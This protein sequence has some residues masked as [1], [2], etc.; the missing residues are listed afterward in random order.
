SMFD[1]IGSSSI[2]RKALASSKSKKSLA[3]NG[4]RFCKEFETTGS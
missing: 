1:E 4:V 3:S 2:A